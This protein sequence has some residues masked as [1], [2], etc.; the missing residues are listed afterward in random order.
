[1]GPEEKGKGFGAL[2]IVAYFTA[3]YLETLNLH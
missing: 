3:F 2:I 1:M